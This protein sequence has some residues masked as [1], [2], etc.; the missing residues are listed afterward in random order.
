M[1]KKLLESINS[2]QEYKS[3]VKH[4]RSAVGRQEQEIKGLISDKRELEN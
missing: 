2:K 4:L 3:E 1:E